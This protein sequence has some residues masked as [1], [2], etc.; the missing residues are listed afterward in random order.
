MVK[1]W[2]A[3]LSFLV[4]AFPLSVEDNIWSLQKSPPPLS[5]EAVEVETEII[6]QEWQEFL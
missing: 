3:N 1:N 5:L 2:I 6:F 4:P